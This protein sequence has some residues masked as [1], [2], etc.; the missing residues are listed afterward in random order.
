MSVRQHDVAISQYSAA[1]SLDLHNPQTLF[2]K[3][4]KARANMGLWQDAIDDANEV[5]HLAL[6]KIILC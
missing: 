6:F 1:L 5:P 2:V 4:S 3:R